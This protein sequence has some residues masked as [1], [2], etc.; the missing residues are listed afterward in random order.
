EFDLVVKPGANPRAIRMK[1]G[2]GRKLSVDSAGDLVIGES[3]GDLRIALP[4]IYQEVDGV[5]KKIAGRYAIRGR[6]EVAFKVDSWD[7][8]KALVI[9]PTIV[10][11]S[12][13]GG[14][15][16][17]Q[18][19]YGIKLDSAGNIIIAGATL[20]ADFP[21]VSA[22]QGT[23]TGTSYTG[24]VAKI[25]PAGTA[26]IY[27]TY[28][29]GST[30]GIIRNLAVD[31]S[32]SAWVTGYTESSNFPVLNAAQSIFGAGLYD[33]FVA[34]LDAAGVLQFSTYLGG[35][36]QDYGYGVAVDPSGNGYVTGYSTGSFPTTAGVLQTTVQG[37]ENVFVAKYGPTGTLLYSSL[38]GG[39]G[40]DYGFGIAADAAGD[41]YVT[42]YAWSPSIPGA[43]AGGAQATNNGGGDA[44][45]AKLNPT[46]T[47]LVYFTYLGGTSLDEGNAIALDGSLNAYIV[48]YS[49]SA[50]LATAGADQTAPSVTGSFAAYDAFAA[51]LNAAGTAFDYVTYLG[52]TR[53]DSAT[54]VAVDGAGNAY[55]S[56]YTDS[57][58]F[59]TSSAVQPV[60]PGSGTS[61]FSTSDS[62]AN[63]SATD[64]NI[65]GAVFDVSLNP[66]GTSG[67]VLTEAGIYRTTNGGASWTLQSQIS[68]SGSTSFLS[69]S[70][71]APSTIYAVRCCSSVYQS[72]DDGV[73][74]NFKGSPP[75][76]QARGILA[77]PLN[78]GTIYIWG[79]NSPYVFASAD[80]GATWSSAATGLPGV[81][82][83]SIV[84]TSDGSLYAGT[85]GAGIYKSA[86]QGASWAAVNTG[87]PSSAYVDF[88]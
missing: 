53:Q 29:G 61:L 88:S 74:W 30:Y 65:P 32:G 27:S 19:G 43:P 70:P 11:S 33:A 55:V 8:S 78:A 13:L 36:G 47:A 68:G 2:G 10:Y 67:V 86:N 62:G 85:N 40:P 83:T 75:S 84:A 79:F 50:G 34:K 38:L 46:G 59:P 71:I 18:V 77:D 35:S 20:A 80:G 56:G 54:G 81:T 12:L 17:S 5:R 16:G 1:V 22:A 57:E 24:F 87:L 7:R 28:L 21:L 51:K 63:W 49:S 26:L 14:G 4:N 41:A 15:L 66:A 64:S 44:F 76:G 72:T 3:D 37:P 31:S 9:D 52:G 82:V 45:V 42:G 6:D 73:T 39:S 69:R 23:K 25:N 58:N 48:G 60:L